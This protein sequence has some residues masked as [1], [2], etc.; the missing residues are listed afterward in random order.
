MA[1]HTTTSCD[2]CGTILNQ[3]RNGIAKVIKQ[4]TTFR[5]RYVTLGA[6]SYSSKDYELCED[7]FKGVQ[8]FIENKHD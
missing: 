6:A 5:K 7:C 4:V 8:N 3:P 2:R 1:R